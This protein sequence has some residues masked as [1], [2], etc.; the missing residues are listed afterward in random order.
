M[1]LTRATSGRYV[2]AVSRKRR[3][4][5][6]VYGAYVV[7]VALFVVSSTYQVARVV[8][9][10]RQDMAAHEA[11]AAPKVS[12]ECSAVLNREVEAID[13][14][15][16]QA[17]KATTADSAQDRFV[18]QRRSATSRDDLERACASDPHG[19]EALASLARYE[20]A[21]QA[22]A[23]REARELVPVRLAAQS[24]IRGHSR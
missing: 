14:A 16:L 22:H 5:R 17:S 3:V 20:R 11:L 4:T 19:T 9:G 2:L 12:G 6:I 21:S 1:R 15:R 23:V 7:G 13:A 18:E 10:G 8:F 24:F